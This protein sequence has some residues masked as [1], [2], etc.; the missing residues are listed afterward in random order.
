MKIVPS[1]PRIRWPTIHAPSTWPAYLTSSDVYFLWAELWHQREQR[2]LQRG[3]VQNANA[4]PNKTRR[5]LSASQWCTNSYCRFNARGK[6]P[7]WSIAGNHLHQQHVTSLIR[8][9]EPLIIILLQ[10]HQ[11]LFHFISFHYY[12]NDLPRRN[13]DR[14]LQSLRQAILI[15]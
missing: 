4:R 12:Q 15:L 13:Q 6:L 14:L 7:R 2:S 1:I 5:S 3:E 8:P 11:R 10:K 9:F